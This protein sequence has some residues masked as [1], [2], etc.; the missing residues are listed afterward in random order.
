MRKEQQVFSPLCAVKCTNVSFTKTISSEW[1]LSCFVR[2]HFNQGWLI[3]IVSSVRI[4]TR[5]TKRLQRLSS[6][7]LSAKNLCDFYSFFLI[8]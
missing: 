2:L 5:G 4:S 3:N 7:Q 1:K 6:L 8:K